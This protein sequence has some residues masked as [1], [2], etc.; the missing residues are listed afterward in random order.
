MA[1]SRPGEQLAK[2]SRL[3]AEAAADSRALAVLV[4][5]RAELSLDHS[6]GGEPRGARDGRVALR[7]KGLGSADQLPL[8]YLRTQLTTRRYHSEMTESLAWSVSRIRGEA[9]NISFV[10]CLGWDGGGTAVSSSAWE[11]RSLDWDLAEKF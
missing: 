10:E 9:E 5:T 11:P 1:G 7:M 8:P 4:A 2:P 6:W 3:V